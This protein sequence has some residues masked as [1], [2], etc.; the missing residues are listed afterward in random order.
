MS[1]N[2]ELNFEIYVGDLCDEA[3]IKTEK[4]L[5]KFSEDLHQLVENAIRDYASDNDIEDYCPMF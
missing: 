1:R 2:D 5:T 4:E 3:N